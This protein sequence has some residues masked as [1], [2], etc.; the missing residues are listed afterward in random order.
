EAVFR[1]PSAARATLQGLA[2]QLRSG[3]QRVTLTGTTATDGTEQYRNTLS[4]QRAG[5][6]RDVL[7]SLGVAA[8]RIAPPVGVGSHG[9]N[10]VN[11]LAADGSLLPGPAAHNRSVVVTLACPQ[12]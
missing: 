2:D 6:V 10:H 5:A 11:D 12:T 3:R 4:L 1:N 8:D 9:P 7:I